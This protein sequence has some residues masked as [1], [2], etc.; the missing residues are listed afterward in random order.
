GSA[1]NQSCLSGGRIDPVE[2]RLD[3]FMSPG[4][5]SLV[6]INGERIE[7]GVELPAH[8]VET[9]IA[10]VEK[11]IAVKGEGNGWIGRHSGCANDRRHAALCIYR[12]DVVAE[13]SDEEPA[14]RF[15][16]IEDVKAQSG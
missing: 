5:R 3:M 14:A 2:G 10:E 12:V 1:A 11:A 7:G 13:I 8:R 4:W 16:E 9:F 15:S 6:W